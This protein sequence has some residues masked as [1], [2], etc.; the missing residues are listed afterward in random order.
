MILPIASPLHTPE[1]GALAP[2][3]AMRP[4]ARAPGWYN[5]FG[6]CRSASIKPP[7]PERA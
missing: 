7:M 2:V 4:G 5:I 6:T 3:W 1:I